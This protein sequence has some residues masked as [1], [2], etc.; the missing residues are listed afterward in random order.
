MSTP[1]PL[2]CLSLIFKDRA[3]QPVEVLH[4][5]EMQSRRL[6]KPNPYEIVNRNNVVVTII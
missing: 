4:Q 5:M 2:S 3:R 1:T 6:A